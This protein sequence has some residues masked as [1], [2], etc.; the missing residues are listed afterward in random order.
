[1][2]EVIGMMQVISMISKR[3]SSYVQFTVVP[4]RQYPLNMYIVHAVLT[5]IL[6]WI[7]SYMYI[8]HLK[9][10]NRLICWMGGDPPG[11]LIRASTLP[12]T[13]QVPM[14]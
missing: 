11:D 12:N 6:F 9:W 5:L 13:Q 1:M 2:A 4:A 10:G 7:G 8:V 14:R 3:L